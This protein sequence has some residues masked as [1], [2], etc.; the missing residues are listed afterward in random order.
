MPSEYHLTYMSTPN[1]R[2]LL[3]FIPV[4]RFNVRKKTPKC[5]IIISVCHAFALLKNKLKHHNLQPDIILHCVISIAS[6]KV[7]P[8]IWFYPIL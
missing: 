6:W 4:D 7:L 3:Y 2:E 8:I 5:Y 1:V